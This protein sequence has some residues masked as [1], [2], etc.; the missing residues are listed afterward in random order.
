MEIMLDAINK[1]NQLGFNYFVIMHN[2]LKGPI[3]IIIFGMFFLKT[4]SVY[5]HQVLIPYYVHDICS[6]LLH[7]MKGEENKRKEIKYVQ[8]MRI[9][10][11]IQAKMKNSMS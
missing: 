8:R 6:N 5:I 4:S 2:F 7:K 9:K 1:Q 3:P 10:Y 11:S